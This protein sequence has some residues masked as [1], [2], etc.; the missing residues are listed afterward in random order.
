[1]S[2]VAAVA[3]EVDRRRPRPLQRRRSDAK[4]FG[5]ST[6]AQRIWVVFLRCSI[7]DLDFAQIAIWAKSRSRME[8]LRK[9]TQILCAEVDWPKHF[10]SER[11]R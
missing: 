5:Q 9:T 4:C 10:A 11:R 3:T 8:H 2:I 7:R 6:S 1:M